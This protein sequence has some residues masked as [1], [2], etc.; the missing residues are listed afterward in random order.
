[1][2]PNA[3]RLSFAPITHWPNKAVHDVGLNGNEALARITDPK[4]RK[5]L[6]DR[7]VYWQKQGIMSVPTMIFNGKNVIN[8]AQP[9]E[10][11]K[12]ILTD[13]LENKPV[14]VLHHVSL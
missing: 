11:Y 14:K 10:V 5:R 8:G 4:A 2:S 1:M 7:E 13:L 3:P 6:Q 12:Q 9:V